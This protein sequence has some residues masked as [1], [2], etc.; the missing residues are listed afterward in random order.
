MII[1]TFSAANKRSNL[2]PI[3]YSSI[4]NIEFWITD[5]DTTPFLVYDES[6]DMIYSQEALP[7]IPIE[8]GKI[9]FYIIYVHVGF[10]CI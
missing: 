7:K 5:E 6:E 8:E 1:L 10:V 4:E 9:M 3:D 2:D